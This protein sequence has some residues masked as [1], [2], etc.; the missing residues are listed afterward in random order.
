MQ[1]VLDASTACHWRGQGDAWHESVAWALED[2]NCLFEHDV[3]VTDV[4]YRPMG[5]AYTHD[6]PTKTY[7]T[8]NGGQ[9][10]QL[11]TTNQASPMNTISHLNMLGTAI[12]IPNSSRE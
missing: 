2:A 6:K 8:S 1:V 5:W 3:P 10:G 9:S 12:T 7:T 4:P 11:P